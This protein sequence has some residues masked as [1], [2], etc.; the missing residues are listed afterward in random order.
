MFSLLLCA[1]CVQHMSFIPLCT[2]LPSS[3]TSNIQI[4]GLF[5]GPGKGVLALR[6]YFL[7]RSSSNVSESILDPGKHIT[8]R[9]TMDPR[10]DD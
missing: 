7:L 5:H 4:S 10:F 9:R 3:V 1:T 8:D 2:K 6:S